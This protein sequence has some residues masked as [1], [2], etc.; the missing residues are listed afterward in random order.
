MRLLKLDDSGMLSL[1]GPLNRDI[2]E[3]AILSHT[4][5]PGGEEVTYEDMIKGTGKD[6]PGYAKLQFYAEQACQH[7][8]RYSWVD[9]CYINKSI[10]P[11]LDEA[12]RSMF[13][14]YAAAARCYV[15]LSDV[16]DLKDLTSTVKSAF[17][18]SRWFT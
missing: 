2:P 10:G 15:Y 4:W 6:K 11:E 9:T 13:R 3:Y 18:K 5:G 17:A 14:W 1:I 16:P 12:I 8:L 7:G